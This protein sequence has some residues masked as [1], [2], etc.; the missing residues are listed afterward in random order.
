MAVV[1]RRAPSRR[2]GEPSA[3]PTRPGHR[4]PSRRRRWLLGLKLCLL[5]VVAAVL[6][7]TS[8]GGT[9]AYIA[10]S[11]HS[12]LPTI[13]EGDLV[14]TRTQGSYR[15]GDPIVYKVPEGDV[16]AGQAVVHRIV[17][18]DAGSGFTMR[19]DNNSFTDPWQP[20]PR[21]IV[22]RVVLDIPLVGRVM[23]YLM[24]PINLGILCGSLTVTAL[25]WPNRR[26]GTATIT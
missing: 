15:V 10:V 9:I 22:G 2:G 5:A 25:L 24:R 11:G 4:A 3:V 23:V 18:G 20:R 13:H 8:L 16:A 12:M 17:G 19:G 26:R 1:L 14:V 6:W 7:P 21:H